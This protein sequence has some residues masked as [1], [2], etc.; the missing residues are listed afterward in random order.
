MTF[1][2][3]EVSLRRSA[4]RYGEILVETNGDV[5]K[6]LEMERVDP[7]ALGDCLSDL[8]EMRGYTKEDHLGPLIEGFLL[9]LGA[10]RRESMVPDSPILL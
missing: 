8:A 10:G 9:G 1:M 5:D 3:D 2:V 4:V 6:M 7:A